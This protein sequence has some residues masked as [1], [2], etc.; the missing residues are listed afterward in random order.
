MSLTAERL[1]ELLRYDPGTGI[2][3]WLIWRSRSARAGDIAGHVYSNGYVY[4]KIEGRNYLAHR[5]AWLY[6]TGEWPKDEID[7]ENTIRSENWWDNLREA[8]GFQNKANTKKSAA[9]T[10]GLKGVSF[11]RRSNKW[12]AQIK[13]QGRHHYLGLF[14]APEAA[15]AA[16][17]N[18]ARRLHGAFAR[19]T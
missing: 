7:H 16:Y 14:D 12:M 9:N 18:A 17:A 5:L 15:H 11:H 13:S 8:T 10:S 3:S 2:F 1:R 6:M 19:P 4:I